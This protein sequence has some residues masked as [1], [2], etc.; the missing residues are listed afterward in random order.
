MK[1]RALQN[2]YIKLDSKQEISFDARNGTV[3]IPPPDVKVFLHWLNDKG[4]LVSTCTLTYATLVNDK[5]NII[6]ASKQSISIHA[7]SL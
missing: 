5:V 2:H 4:K 1:Y 3:L 6:N 7:I